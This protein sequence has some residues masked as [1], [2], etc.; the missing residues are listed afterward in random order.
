MKHH[1]HSTLENKAFGLV[2]A[3]IFRGL[4]YHIMTGSLV[5]DR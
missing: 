3:F 2:L 5:A 1:D 4:V